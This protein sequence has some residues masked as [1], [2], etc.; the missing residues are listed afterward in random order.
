[1]TTNDLLCSTSHSFTVRL[2]NGPLCGCEYQLSTPRTLFLVGDTQTLIP[3]EAAADLPADSLYIP[4]ASGG[5]NFEIVLVSEQKNQLI[6]RELG[7]N[8]TPEHNIVF[9]E[10]FSVGSLTLAVRPTKEPW[11]NTVLSYPK[12]TPIPTREIPQRNKIAIV[13]FIGLLLMLLASG[14]YW[15]QH[16]QPRQSRELASLLG[17]EAT[18]FQ[19]IP[20]RNGLLYVSANNERDRSWAKQVLA[21]GDYHEPATV[22]SPQQE[23]ERITRWLANNYPDLAYYRLQLDNPLKPQLWISRQRTTLGEPQQKTLLKKLT[24]QLPYA[25]QLLLQMVDDNLAVNSAE[26]GLIQQALPYS[27]TERSGNVTF[28][29]E[30]AL[31]DGEL[32]RAQRFVEDYYRQWGTRYVQFAIELKDDW[33]KGKSFKYGGQGYVKMAPG[34]WYFPKPL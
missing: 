19:V 16:S 27:R 2:L 11:T 17:N 4:L 5:I 24:E 18:R 30:G 3:A 25:D 23:N 32:L 21:R 34:H 13:L 15:L 26:N 14:Y 8:A 9:N 29:I 20:G 1:M 12:A 10:P 33:L 7:S 31:N 28:L 6:L 22:I